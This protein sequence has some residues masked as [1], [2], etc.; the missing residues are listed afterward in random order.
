MLWCTLFQ[1]GIRSGIQLDSLQLV[2]EAF[3]FSSK[4]IF[5]EISYHDWR[6][7]I[8]WKSR[9]TDPRS[10]LFL[11]K[12]NPPLISWWAMWT[13]VMKITRQQTFLSISKLLRSCL[14]QIYCLFKLNRHQILPFDLSQK[15]FHVRLKREYL[16]WISCCR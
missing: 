16:L 10:V 9:H 13:H 2:N 14:L 15:T 12:C 5:S 11:Q 1:I 3:R 7:T 6:P 8:S 4:H